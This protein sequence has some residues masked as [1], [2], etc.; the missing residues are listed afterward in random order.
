MATLSGSR[1]LVVDDDATLARS[2]RFC[3][4]DAGYAVQTAQSVAQALQRLSENVFDLCFLDLNIGEESGLDLLPRLRAEAPWMRVV[5]VTAV[6]GTS[7]AVTAMQRG[8]LDYLVKPCSA[9]QLVQSAARQTRARR[10]ELEIE[11][12]QDAMQN[13]EPAPASISSS[14]PEMMKLLDTARAVADTDAAVLILGESGT[15]K[16]VLARAIHQWSLRR[17]APFAT[18]NCPSLNPELL[19]SELFGHVRGAFTGATENRLGRVQAANQ[20][21]LFLDEIGDFPL[22][23]QPKLLR[24]LQ[25]REYERVGDPKTHRADVRLIAATNCNLEAMVAEGRF[26][27]DLFYRLNVITLVV[28][29]LRE[30]SDEVPVLAKDFLLGFA[31][32]Y[33]RPARQFSAA[34]IAA[35]RRYH[36][37]GNIRELRN[38]VERVAILCPGETV[39]EQQLPLPAT[40]GSSPRKGSLRAGDACSLE[41][42][43]KAHIEATLARLGSLDEAAELLGINAS[44]LYRKRKAYAL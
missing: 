27:N 19:E 16:N 36:W 35:L 24:F 3:L 11:T 9:E 12:L 21:T 33:R 17:E 25:D 31:A 34:A 32:R 30:R 44:T 41:A 13:G 29:P 18:V 42:L 38:L 15:G 6:N 1:V 8:A 22:A 23:L 5:M 43:E 28:P 26:R 10:M 20:G 40:Q 37:P 2:F 4:E 39:E 7:T 14:H